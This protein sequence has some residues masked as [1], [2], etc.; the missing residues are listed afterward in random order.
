MNINSFK[1][2]L[3]LLLK[4]NVVPFVWGKQGVGK[5]QTVKQV[6]KEFGPDFGFVHLHL[7]TQE[8]GDLVGLLKENKDG[9]VSHMR[10]EWFPTTGK[11][12]VFL[13][14]LNRAHPDCI[15]AMFSFI[16]D[17]SIHQHRLPE[18]WKIVAA[19]NY[20]SEE[21]TVTDTSDA[22]WMS[23]FCHIHFTP[24]VEEFVRYAGDKGYDEV[25]DFI[26][27][28][29]EMLESKSKP[30]DVNVIPDRRSW[31]DMIAP[32]NKETMTDE[33]RFEVYSGIVGTAPASAYM[34]HRTS[35]DKRIKLDDILTDYKKFK[36]RVNTLNKN[37]DTRFD[38]LSA[39]LSELSDRLESEPGLLDEAK[40]KNLHEFL[41]DI[42]L[43]LAAQTL[44]KFNS[45]N[46]HL[47]DKLVNDAKFL[48]KL[49]KK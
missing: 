21:F 37:K 6:A 16:T 23:R 13:D 48:N 4:N 8:P 36:K 31:C 33:D 27:E 7:A 15:Q 34:A 5:T 2:V 41:L 40:L 38:L 17:K 24:T 9:A 12:I 47:R 42:P 30:V 11:G 10:P 19:G 25:A 3:P 49:F 46:F 35:K 26:S 39:P 18:G 20:S 1:K 28:N 29:P 43:E 22:A 14:E 44:K 45:F 32:L